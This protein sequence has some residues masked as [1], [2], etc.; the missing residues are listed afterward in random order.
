MFLNVSSDLAFRT[1]S[2]HFFHVEM[3]RLGKKMREPLFLVHVNLS[4]TPIV[5]ADFL[6]MRYLS[7]ELGEIERDKRIDQLEN[8]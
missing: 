6:S 7:E 5:T 2:G 1:G 3:A 8:H 4:E